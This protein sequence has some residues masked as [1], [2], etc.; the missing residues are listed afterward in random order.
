MSSAHVETSSGLEANAHFHTKTFILLLAVNC[1]YLAQTFNLVASGSLGLSI[2]AAV[3]GRSSMVWLTSVLGIMTV[4]LSPP[5]SQAADYWGRKWFLVGLTIMGCVG[6]I[7]VSRADSIGMVIAGLAVSGFSYG[8]QP[9]IHAVISEVLPRKYRSYAQATANMS[10]AL[11]AICALLVGGALIQNPTA[12]GFRTYWY[13]TAGVYA[14]TALGVGLLYNPPPRELQMN[15]TLGQKVRRLDWIG[16]ALLAIGLVLFCLGLSWAQNPY[17]WKSFNVLATFLVGL[18]F[19]AGLI[20]Y[21]WRFRGDAMICIFCEGITFYCANNYFAFEVS[22]FYTTNPLSV[23]LHYSITFFAFLSSALAAGVYCW[24]TKSLR[25]PTCFAFGL[26]LVFNILVATANKNTAV[27]NIWAYPLFLGAGLGIALTALMVAAQFSTPAE[28]IAIASGLM[29][30]V[31]SLGGTIGLAIYN[32]IFNDSLSRNLAS[33][34]AAATLPLGL[35]D[36]SLG[37]FIG[38]L[39]ANNITALGEITRGNTTIIG[40]GASALLDAYAVAFRNVWIAAGA[41]AAL[42]VL[43]SI[44]MTDPRAEFN[45]RIDAPVEVEAKVYTEDNVSIV[46]PAPHFHSILS[47]INV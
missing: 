25:L 31:R 43:V 12:E 11:G 13:I 46:K 42:A 44:F 32:A 41:F 5:V 7:V 15:L 45:A 33:K 8:C 22:L 24:K 37:P 21:E 10:I 23:G 35:P 19:T 28:H 27:R 1:V 29:I 39:A 36:T 38:A 2:T 4:V 3:G 6:S 9:L 16:F 26:I 14:A 34:I 17:P 40:A 20:I 18:V 30:S 47:N